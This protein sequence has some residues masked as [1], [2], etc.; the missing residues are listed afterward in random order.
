MGRGTSITLHLKEDAEE[1]LKEDKLLA[2]VSRY[3]QFV[4][5]PILLEVE[6]T[7]TKEVPIEE[8]VRTLSYASSWN[9]TLHRNVFLQAT[10]EGEEE[11]NV[12]VSEEEDAD[13]E[14]EDDEPKT[15]TI[16]EKVKE[17][18]RVNEVYCQ[19]PSGHFYFST[20]LTSSPQTSPTT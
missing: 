3:S 18:K 19:F 9:Q 17:W 10:A 4:N 12:E 14:D 13:V 7:I 2:I 1:F 15:K 11:D 6:K 16:Q 20:V 8:E 5:V